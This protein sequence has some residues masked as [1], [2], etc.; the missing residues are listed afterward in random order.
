MS[1]VRRCDG[2]F[3]KACNHSI[4][5]ALLVAFVLAFVFVAPQAQAQSAGDSIE[6]TDLAGRTV[7]VKKGVQRMILGEGRQLYGLAVLDKDNP[8]KRVVGWRD[9]L[10][11]NDPDAWRKYRGKF[12]QADQI[13]DFGNPYTSDFSVEKVVALN[14][15]V[16]VLDLGNYF[17]AQETG[18]IAKLE[19]VGIP[20][21]FIDWREDPSQNTLPSLILLGRIMDREK[22]ALAFADFYLRQMRLVYTRVGNIKEKDRPLV[23][24]ERAAGYNPNNCCSTWGAT[25]FG[26][27]VEDAGGRNW[28]S[29]FFSSTSGGDVNIEKVVADDPDYFLMTGANWSEAMPSSIAAPMGYEATD[30]KVQSRLKALMERPGL[31]LLRAVREKHVMVLYHQFYN[32]PY[33]FIAVQAIAKMLHPDRFKDVDPQA[34]WEELHAKFLPVAPSGIFWAVMK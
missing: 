19:K 33:S 17:K 15:D 11:V 23:F 24:M 18:V 27:F 8:F 26:K 30:E 13:A 12:P 21:V 31:S 22:E 6:V 32:S 7:R 10:K 34:N 25:N 2:Q 1:T 29:R 5:F 3:A 4:T 28:G 9:D 20:V 16:V 14:A